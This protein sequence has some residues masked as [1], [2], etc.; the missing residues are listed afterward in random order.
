MKDLTTDTTP[1]V[2][3]VGPREILELAYDRQSWIG[4]RVEHVELIDD[5]TIQQITEL[6]IDLREKGWAVDDSQ[7]STVLLPVMRLSRDS[8]VT[9]SVMNATGELLPRPSRRKEREVVAAGILDGLDVGLDLL[10][11]FINYIDSPLTS[12]NSEENQIAREAKAYKLLLEV[13]TRTKADRRKL[14]D[15]RA[16]MDDFSVDRLVLAEFPASVLQM[17]SVTRLQQT[18]SLPVRSLRAKFY[19]AFLGT[20]SMGAWIEAPGAMTAKSFHIIARAPAG[21]RIEDMKL[22]VTHG[23]EGEQK[24]LCSYDDDHQLS[25]GHTCISVP[26]G[27]VAPSARCRIH[28]YSN[29]TGFFFESLLIAILTSILLAVF[30]THLRN[31]GFEFAEPIVDADFA[32]SLVLLFPVLAITIVTQR[33]AHRLASMAFAAQRLFVAAIA[34]AAAAASIPIAL[35]LDPGRATL[36][37][38][39]SAAICW[40]ATTRVIFV[41]TIHAWRIRHAAN[42]RTVEES[43]LQV[44]MRNARN[45]RDD[46]RRRRTSSNNR[47][48]ENPQ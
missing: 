3:G 15:I 43:F 31:N 13:A 12:S 30:T 7:N 18:R 32:A 27:L 9:V 19:R 2:S 41:S 47:D 22:E 16:R 45:F 17:P 48:L 28:F 24:P 20:L 36:W 38:Y 8:H 14:F 25:I 26:E 34:V 42:S 11:E 37:W 6:H 39:G 33:D 23:V 21:F 10:E 4:R 5:R 35:I 44:T 29:K 46:I 1:V 40:L